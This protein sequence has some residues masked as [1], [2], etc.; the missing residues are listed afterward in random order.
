MGRLIF[1]LVIFSIICTF[2]NENVTSSYIK[3]KRGGS[4]VPGRHPE[5]K[6]GIGCP[7][8]TGKFGAC[9][10]LCR[11]KNT[12][13]YVFANVENT[14]DCKPGELCCFNGCGYNCM[15]IDQGK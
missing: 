10:F 4:W 12:E 13:G 7:Q 3:T 5:G 8:T 6:P 14:E 9:A 2:W 15:L 11:P 1:G